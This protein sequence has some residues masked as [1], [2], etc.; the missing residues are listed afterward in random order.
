VQVA[1]PLHDHD[2]VQVVAAGQVT[3]LPP[4]LPEPL[5]VSE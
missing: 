5:H 2:G 3:V 4:H 1:V